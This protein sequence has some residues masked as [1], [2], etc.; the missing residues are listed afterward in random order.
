MSKPLVG[1]LHSPLSNL[2]P[3][4]GQRGAIRNSTQ[5]RYPLPPQIRRPPEGPKTKGGGN[6]NQA[7][8][9]S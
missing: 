8:A 4:M 5:V 6:R 2:F 3:P 9:A 7:Q 1:L